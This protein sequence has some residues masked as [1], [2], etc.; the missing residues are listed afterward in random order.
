MNKICSLDWL[1]LN[2]FISR[3]RPAWLFLAILGFALLS[4]CAS[5]PKKSHYS[6]GTT[7]A[8]ISRIILKRHKRL[9]GTWLAIDKNGDM[10]AG[11]IDFQPNGLVLI[12][13][14][15]RGVMIGKWKSTL[16][17]IHISLPH[18]G[19]SSIRFKFSTTKPVILV[20]LFKTGEIK[21][22]ARLPVNQ[23][24]LNENSTLH[25]HSR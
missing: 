7:T 23:G 19:K 4:A 11:T 17:N 13:P 6:Q 2:T 5:I 18:N 22:F 10:R 1:M 8:K 25:P 12:D 21:E 24:K 15:N 14:N 20:L 9:F 3:T 16:N